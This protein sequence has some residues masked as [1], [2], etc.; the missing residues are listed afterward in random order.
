MCGKNVEQPVT[1]EFEPVESEYPITIP[2]EAGVGVEREI[3]L[4]D[5]ADSVQYVPLETNDKCLID[6]IN[7]GKV[8]KTGKY[9]FVSSN[10]RLYQYTTDG[11]FVRTSV[12]GW[13]SRTIQLFPTDRC[14]RGYGLIFMLTTS[15]KINVYEMETGKF[16]YD[17]KIPDKETAQFAMLNDTLVATFMLNSSG[18]QKERIY[19]SSQKENILNTFYRSTCLKSKA[20][21]GG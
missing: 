17:I 21:L 5:I 12:R 14:E 4:S 6:F 19:I 16:L 3:K 10:T 7:S 13:W 8:V 18:Q 15:G 2:F 11:K 1:V 9:W 20:E